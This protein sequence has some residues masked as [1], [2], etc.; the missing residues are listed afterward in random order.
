MRM[1]IAIQ[2]Y[3]VDEICTELA[4]LTGREKYSRQ[5]INLLVKQRIPA[6]IKF[7]RQYLLTEEQLNFLAD[8]LKPSGRPKSIVIKQ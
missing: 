4:K 3:D 7:G 5:R 8:E 2:V 6:P 1:L